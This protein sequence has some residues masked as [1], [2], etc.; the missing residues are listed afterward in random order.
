M[1]E[2]KPKCPACEKKSIELRNRFFE[3]KKLKEDLQKAMD[4]KNGIL[5]TIEPIR[6]ERDKYFEEAKRYR[7]EL[8]KTKK[9][10]ETSLEKINKLEQQYKA[11]KEKAILY[12]EIE[13]DYKD[14]DMSCDDDWD[15]NKNK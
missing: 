1:T 3:N 10:L 9:T 4:D 13:N 8:E 14:F 15:W 12:D 2:Q 7:Y 11:L 6:Q 5:T